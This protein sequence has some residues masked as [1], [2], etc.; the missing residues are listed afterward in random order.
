MPDGKYSFKTIVPV[1]YK[2]SATSWRPAHIHLRVSSPNHQDLITQIYFKGDPYLDQDSSSASPLAVN[3][4][5]DIT[6]DPANQKS[7]NLQRD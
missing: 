6:T 1:P 3:R 2:A 5:L 4:I 7:T